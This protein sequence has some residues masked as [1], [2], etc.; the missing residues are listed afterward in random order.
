MSGIHVKSPD[1]V[2]GNS[3]DELILENPIGNQGG[4]HGKH[5]CCMGISKT[6]EK[7]AGLLF[8]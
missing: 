1:F 4:F 5:F 3:S 2:M 8:V 7:M 6:G